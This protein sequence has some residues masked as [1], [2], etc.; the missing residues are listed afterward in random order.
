[1]FAWFQNR[2][3]KAVPTAPPPPP[4]PLPPEETDGLTPDS[5]IPFGYKTGWLC[6]QSGDP[7]AVL[8]A[9]GLRGAARRRVTGGRAWTAW[10]GRE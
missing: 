10:T 2:K 4:V 1:M 9:L 5:P 7:Q 6:I 8:E 3:K